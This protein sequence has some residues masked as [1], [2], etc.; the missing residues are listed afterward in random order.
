MRIVDEG[1]RDGDALAL[2]AREFVRQV[3][4][5]VGKSHSGEHLCRP[6]CPF[7]ALYPRIDKR[8]SYVVEGRDARQQVEILKDEADLLV[9]R[10][11]KSIVAES[12]DLRTVEQIGAF[13]RTIETAEDI[14]EGRFSG[15]GRPH[16]RGK[17]TAPYIEIDA[18][19]CGKGLAADAVEFSYPAQ[20]DGQ[21]CFFCLHQTP[22][23]SER[24]RTAR[25]YTHR[26]DLRRVGADD[27]LALAEPR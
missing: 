14:H 6:R 3:L 21:G 4:S 15:A 9:A 23:V 25:L 5:A 18:I 24:R 19:E 2:S 8:Q 13:R 1:A 10:H 16:E 17:V 7:T 26:D 12:C 27:A 22:P 20:A 11:G